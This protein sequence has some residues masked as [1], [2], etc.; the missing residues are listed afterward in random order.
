MTKDTKNNTYDGT[1]T[2][3]E[4]ILITP[5]MAKVMMNANID[6]RPRSAARVATIAARMKAGLWTF[7]HQGIGIRAD[8]RILDGQHRL[9]AIISS[10]VAT[11]FNVTT[12]LGDVFDDIDKGGTRTASDLVTR[13][14]NKK[15]YA[16]S[17]CAMAA[18]AMR[19]LRAVKIEKDDVVDM[20]DWYQ[21]QLNPIAAELKKVIGK[22]GNAAVGGAF[23]SCMRGDDGWIGAHGGRDPDTVQLILMRYTA[24]EWKGANDPMKAL[25]TRLLKSETSTKVGVNFNGQEIYGLTVAALRAELSGRTMQAKSLSPA[26][27]DWGEPGD[28]GQKPRTLP[29]VGGEHVATTTDETKGEV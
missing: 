1:G 29:K 25:F 18:A 23:L 5:D 6:N 8:G 17:M 3:T 27:I 2:K 9:A 16:V 12:G 7:T 22:M 26:T 24:M 14:L 28:H 20:T 4:R 19:G 11:P 21:D 10:G 15:G 13:R